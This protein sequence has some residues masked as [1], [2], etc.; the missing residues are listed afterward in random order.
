VLGHCRLAIL[1]LSQAGNQP[2][3]AAESGC[4]IV[5]NGECY[6]HADLRRRMRVPF[7]STSDTETV[8]HWLAERWESG[9]A[10]LRGM[11]ALALWDERRGRLLL[12]RDPF[13][14]KPLYYATPAAGGLVFASEVR[15]LLA[16]GLVPPVVG[17]QALAHYLLYGFVGEPDA[18]VAGVQA[19]P[20]GGWLEW[21]PASGER[22]SG[23]FASCGAGLSHPVAADPRALPERFTAS[24]ASHLL[25]D[26][27]VGAFLSG[28]VDS[29]AIASAMVASGADTRTLTVTFPEA[30][31]ACEGVQAAAWARHLGTKHCEVPVTARDLLADLAGALAA[32]DQ[33]TVDAVNTYV[34]S[35]AAKEAGLKVVLSGLGGDE[36][37]GGYPV[38]QDVPRQLGVNRLPAPLRRLGAT[39]AE[40]CAP[41]FWRRPHKIA[42]IL[43]HGSSLRTHYA[44]RRRLFTPGQ[45]HRLLR[46]EAPWTLS[47]P[48]EAPSG[49]AAAD[50]IAAL[51]LSFYM[52]CQLLRDSD[53]MSMAHSIELRVPFI[54]SQFAQYALSLGPL[55]RQRKSMFIRE[56]AALLPAD[57][58]SRPKR[59]F[60]MPFAAWLTGPLRE[61]VTSRLDDMARDLACL[62]PVAVKELW[63]SF[64]RHPDQVGW[65]RPW[66]LF[67][68]GE[69]VAAQGLALA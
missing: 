33:P 11:F 68:L 16:T 46:P 69:Y 6:N 56:C 7:R 4:T 12:A 35:R 19:L 51:D 41:P 28:G 1:D 20:P 53:C 58:G 17:T 48:P 55:A 27:P 30:P 2:M 23:S 44:C 60:T 10:E 18:I 25:S 65:S 43:R 54:D 40:S 50:E 59:G 62:D 67:C 3:T 64:L 63:R 36:L 47:L 37:F 21:S 42:D 61:T 9:L 32:Q 34:V 31:E 52:R 22:R 24:V 66:A 39:L 57:I 14:I 5:Y 26:V 29:S 15:A 13:G 8:L 49:L 45:V 38:F